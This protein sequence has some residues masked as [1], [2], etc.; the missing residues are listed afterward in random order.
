MAIGLVRRSA[1]AKGIFA[2]SAIALSLMAWG[3][4]G[5]THDTIVNANNGDASVDGKAG[6]GGTGGAGGA[7]G[8]GG[9]TAGAGGTG[10]AGGRAAPAERR[11]TRAEAMRTQHPAT[12]AR[13]AARR[14]RMPPRSTCPR[15]SARGSCSG[16]TRPRA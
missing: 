15:R 16:S 1:Y 2:T 9:S 6:T 3:C 12:A 7:G 11:R 8:T 10:G 4:G 5:D 14:M 13:T